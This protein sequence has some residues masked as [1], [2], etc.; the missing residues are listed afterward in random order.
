MRF[1]KYIFI[2]LLLIG[3]MALTACS[4]DNP[5]PDAGNTPRTVLVYMIATNNLGSGSAHFDTNDIDEMLDAAAAGALGKSR[6]LVF[7]HSRLTP[8]AP[9]LLE[10]TRKGAVELKTYSLTASSASEEV[11]NQVIADMKTLAPARSYGMMFWSHSTGWLNNGIDTPAKAAP[12]SFGYDTTPRNTMSV[13]S[14]RNVLTGKGFDF[15]Y[16][17]CCFMATAEVAYEL[18]DCAE[19]MVGSAAEL[20]ANGTPYHI[21]LPYLMK[22]DADCVKAAQ[23][24]FNYYNS[25]YNPSSSDADTDGCTFSAIHLPS[26]KPLAEATAKIYS[27]KAEVKNPETVQDFAPALYPGKFCDLL[28]YVDHKD[29]DKS[30]ADYKA[31]TTALKDAVRF[32]G[33][34]PGIHLMNN[35]TVNAHCGLTT[36]LT[37]GESDFSSDNYRAL[38]WYTD[39]ASKLY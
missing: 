30:S 4:G 3:G 37:N 34:T 33:A 8:E 9:K 7:R 23:A 20:P 5:D 38:L 6:L 15:L 18:R 11:M 26:M 17:D 32:E 19:W 16:F 25:C 14:L 10:I 29:I 39:V 36:Y 12:L 27:L 1:F 35:F 13:T 2:T 31:F 21:A 22:E 28:D 24:T